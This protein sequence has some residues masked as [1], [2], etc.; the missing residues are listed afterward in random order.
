MSR[1]AV[2]GAGAIGSWLG[3]ALS[4]AGHDVALLARGAHLE[5]LRR[6]GLRIEHPEETYTVRPLASADPGEVGAVDAVI[7][8][9]KAHAQPGA[10]PA[11]SA[12]LSASDRR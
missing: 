3:A 11:V 2:V 7:L 9:V 4:R 5:A 6:D 10:G 1:I 8:A 12:L